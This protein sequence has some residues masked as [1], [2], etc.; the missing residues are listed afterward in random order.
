MIKWG[1]MSNFRATS[2]ISASRSSQPIAAPVIAANQL[3]FVY[4]LLVASR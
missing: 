3:M 1:I 2:T 4:L